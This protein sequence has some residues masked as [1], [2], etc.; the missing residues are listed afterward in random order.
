MTKKKLTAILT[1]LAN[2]VLLRL[3]DGKPDEAEITQE[4]QMQ[5]NLHVCSAL[6]AK[7][8]EL[9]TAALAKIEADAATAAEK[10]KALEEFR[11]L[12]EARSTG[13]ALH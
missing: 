7:K 10:K 13:T 6:R 3:T 5:A 1:G 12:R 8:D 9:L 11:A 4:E 2:L